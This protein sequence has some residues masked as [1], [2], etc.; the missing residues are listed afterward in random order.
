[1][2]PLF[3]TDPKSSKGA[4]ALLT[5]TSGDTQLRSPWLKGEKFSQFPRWTLL[6]LQRRP[7]FPVFGLVSLSL[8]YPPSQPVFRC[9]RPTVELRVMWQVLATA[10]C[11]HPA[12]ALFQL[13]VATTL[14]AWGEESEKGA[15]CERRGKCGELGSQSG[16][17]PAAYWDYIYFLGLC[18]WTCCRWL[19]GSG[20]RSY[21]IPAGTVWVAGSDESFQS[22]QSST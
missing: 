7:S 11:L 6:L 4:G 20:V 10:C 15:V 18:Y 17:P 13:R 5:T 16:R 2:L 3:Q 9:P 1:M 8:S 12:K 22:E 14:G 21:K 19:K